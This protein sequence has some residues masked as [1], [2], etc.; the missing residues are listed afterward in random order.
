[1]TNARGIANFSARSPGHFSPVFVERFSKSSGIFNE[2]E[3]K[4]TRIKLQKVGRLIASNH[5]S[6]THWTARTRLEPT[7]RIMVRQWLDTFVAKCSR[8]TKKKV[9]PAFC[10]RRRYVRNDQEETRSEKREERAVE[11]VV[12]TRACNTVQLWLHNAAS[13]SLSPSARLFAPVPRSAFWRDTCSRTARCR[14]FLSSFFPFFF[15]FLF[16]PPRIGTMRR[17]RGFCARVSGSHLRPLSPPTRSTNPF[18]Q[19]RRDT[20]VSFITLHF[21][22]PPLWSE[23]AFAKHDVSKGKRAGQIYTRDTHRWKEARELEENS[24]A[25]NREFGNPPGETRLR[26]F[27]P[28]SPMSHHDDRVSCEPIN[29]LPIRSVLTKI[30]V[31][32][33]F[34][35][36]RRND[37]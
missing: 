1:M 26:E 36:T 10:E 19:F 14:E 12:P 6:I 23:R 35:K 15:F 18:F 25:I 29:A 4:F 9:L 27:Y 32:R 11:N 13:D 16:F 20:S 17:F 22:S 7:R 28:R 33:C 31:R 37:V 8:V 34:S 2:K 30:L 24:S 3:R 5:L 21:F